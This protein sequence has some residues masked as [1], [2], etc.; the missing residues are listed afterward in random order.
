MPNEVAKENPFTAMILL[1]AVNLLPIWQ[2]WSGEWTV[3]QLVLLFWLETL[4]LILLDAGMLAL[5][6]T[7]FSDVAHDR[8]F[9]SASGYFALP[10][11]LL[12]AIPLCAAYFLVDIDGVLLSEGHSFATTIGNPSIW[13]VLAIALLVNVVNLKRDLPAFDWQRQ[14]VHQALQRQIL[15]RVV[16]CQVVLIIGAMVAIYLGQP[17]WILLVLVIA[18]TILDMLVYWFAYNDTGPV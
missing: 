3:V 15:G 6:E 18:K 17:L 13:W 10:F 9:S 1:V 16:S 5:P 8:F 12:Q 4:L 2:V 7:R 11:V 14:P